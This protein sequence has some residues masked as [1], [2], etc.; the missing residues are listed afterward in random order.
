MMDETANAQGA[1]GDQAAGL[2]RWANEKPDQ[3][4]ASSQSNTATAP[5]PTTLMVVGMPTTSAAQS[6][7]VSEVLHTWHEDG[8]RWIG[9]PA[10][11][12]IVPLAAESRHL[13]VLAQQQPRW[14]LWVEEGPD[15]FR[16]AYR[17]LKQVYANHGPKRLLVLHPGFSSPR[18]LLN[19][20]RD[21]AESFLGIE[22]LILFKP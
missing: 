3:T 22:L 10:A 20:L 12:R 4:M 9:N 15:G 14:A 5:S 13:P 2:R 21:A 1:R 6:R 18:G 7:R 8:H 16:L 11:W 19:N 17:T